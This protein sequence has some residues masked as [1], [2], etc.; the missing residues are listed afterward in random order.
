MLESRGI[1]FNDE[2][3]AKEYLLNNNYYN[4]VNCFGKFFMNS[5]GKYL[6]GTTFDEITL[7]HY[8][9]KEIKSFFKYIIE[10]EKHLRA[11]I[12]YRYSEFY[13]NQEY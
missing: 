6:E 4:V 9:D 8:F 11:I 12:A 3:K 10:G 1:I 7:V 2:K 5:Q 13:R